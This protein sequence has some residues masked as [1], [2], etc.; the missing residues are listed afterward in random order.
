MT[1]VLYG[2]VQKICPGRCS[3]ISSA[4]PIS[5]AECSLINKEI[6]RFFL[7]EARKKFC[8]ASF[9]F[10]LGLW[11]ESFAKPKFHTERQALFLLLFFF[12]CLFVCFFFLIETDPL[13]PAYGR[14]L[15]LC[16]QATV[17]IIVTISSNTSRNLLNEQLNPCRFPCSNRTP[18]QIVKILA[19]CT[20]FT[21]LN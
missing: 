15:F 8:L 20:S 5:A 11:P 19:S 7:N 16:F 21:V 6:D 9:L 4:V 10:L 13:M 2:G 18:I 3:F 17:V 12:V 1:G 14:G